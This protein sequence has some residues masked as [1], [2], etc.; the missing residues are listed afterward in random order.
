MSLKTVFQIN[1]IIAGLFALFCLIIPTNMLSWYGV[2]SIDATVLMTRFFGISLLAIAL[3][4]F[5][6]K[7]SKYTSTVKSVVLA[8]LLSDLVG[9]IVSIWAM[10]SYTVNSLGWLNVIIYVF[11]TTVLYSIYKTRLPE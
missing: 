8:L 3:I 10:V 11:L 9:V 2:E 4:T 6:L 5:Y 7:G 1:A